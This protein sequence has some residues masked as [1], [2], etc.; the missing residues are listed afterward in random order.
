MAEGDGQDANA[1]ANNPLAN[2]T[3]FNIQHYYVGDFTQPDDEDGN[4][5]FLRYAKPF[6]IGETNWLFRGTLP[7]L[8]LPTGRGGKTENGLGD[9]NAFA[10]YLFDTGNPAISFGLSSQLTVP[11]AT[12]ETLGS[13]KTSESASRR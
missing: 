3:A 10:A 2:L 5:F 1:Q 8:S 12:D 11:S 13:E 4:Q 7:A 9:I 6:Q